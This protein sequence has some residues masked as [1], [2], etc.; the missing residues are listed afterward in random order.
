[1]ISQSKIKYNTIITSLY[2]N[3]PGHSTNGQSFTFIVKYN[4]DG[5]FQWVQWTDGTVNPRMYGE[6]PK[7]KSK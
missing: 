7:K 6:K 2:A 1:M 5:I 3:M 4:S